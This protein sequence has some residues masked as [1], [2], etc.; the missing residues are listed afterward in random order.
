MV[1]KMECMVFV[2]NKIKT[3]KVDV[4]LIGNHYTV[5]S[6]GVKLFIRSG[7]EMAVHASCV[8]KTIARCTFIILFRSTS[9]NSEVNHLT[10]FCYASSA[11]D[12]YTVERI[13]NIFL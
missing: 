13:L 12:G 9:E 4:L 5:L 2:A 7:N 6:N 10:W 11:T 8:N 1:N 3:G